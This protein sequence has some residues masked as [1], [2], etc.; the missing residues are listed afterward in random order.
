MTR[1]ISKNFHIFKVDIIFYKNYSIKYT[2]SRYHKPFYSETI[3]PENNSWKRPILF[4]D[5]NEISELEDV[6]SYIGINIIKQKL[7][8][9]DDFY[10]E[11]EHHRDFWSWANKLRNG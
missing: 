8:W 9:R 11:L 3:S 5:I 1:R 2:I 7:M 6:F 10:K 4:I